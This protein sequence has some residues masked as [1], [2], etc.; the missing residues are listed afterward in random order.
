MIAELNS[1]TFKEAVVTFFKVRSRGPEGLADAT[2]KTYRSNFRAV[3]PHFGHLNMSEIDSAAIKAYVRK[4]REQVSDR[5]VK[6]DL[7]FLSTVFTFAQEHWDGLPDANPVIS[8]SK[9]HLK[10]KGRDYFLTKEEYKRLDG[11]CTEEWQRH[12]LWTAVCTGMRHAELRNLRKDWI[13]FERREIH[14]PREVTKNKLPRVI[15]MMDV[16]GVTMKDWC[17][18]TPSEWVFSHY[19]Q[20]EKAYVPYQSFWNS[21]RSIRARAGLKTLRIHDLRHTFAS[22]WV[23][24]GG[25]LK[26][27][28]VILG[29]STTQMS[30]RYA[31]LDTGATHRAAAQRTWSHFGHTTPNGPVTPVVTP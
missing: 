8:Y 18:R 1:L 27:L 21:F 22:W 5:T 10:V 4:R 25:D 19:S 7:S 2:L 23:Q 28:S 30:E 16:L 3:A 24:D 6:G 14:L 9:K 12:F 11:A 15:P 31:H 13:N 17:D 20:K 29:H 26:T